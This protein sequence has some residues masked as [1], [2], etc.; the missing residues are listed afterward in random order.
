MKFYEAI[1]I[2]PLTVACRFFWYFFISVLWNCWEAL[3][4]PYAT[5]QRYKNPPQPT[6]GNARYADF[7]TLRKK[8]Y[9]KPVGFL[10]CILRRGYFGK[11]VKVYTRSERS[12][13]IMA[14][15]GAGK[16]QHI[17]A[18]LKD[19]AKRPYPVLP[20]LLVG[21]AGNELF[22]ATGPIFKS[23][24]Y[25]LSK[26]DGVEPDLFT[27]YDILSGLSPKFIDRFK[28]QTR[29][30]GICEAMVA[31]EPNSKHPHFVQFARLLLKCV[32]AVDVLYEGNARPICDLV[33][34]LFDDEAREEMLKRAKAYNDVFISKTLK[35]MQ[36][37]QKNGEGVSMMSTALRKLEPWSDPAI[38]EITTF[39][40]DENGKYYRGWNFTQMYS[41][42]K[43]VVLYIR[44]G[45]EDVGGALARIIYSNAVNE[46]SAIWDETNK[47]L[48]R[49]L[50]IY[51]DEA[52]L[53]GNVSAFIKA[54][55]R[56]R[57]V[58]VRLRLCFVGMDELKKVY[59]DDYKTLLNGCDMTVF[60]GGNDT[61]LFKYASDLAGE[62]TVQSK[63]ESE[64]TNGESRGRSE[65]PRKLVKQDEFRRSERLEVYAYVDNLVVKGETTWR[66]NKKGEI[67]HL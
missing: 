19:V 58:W 41:Q 43:P 7:K 18:D 20:F 10:A 1:T 2:W 62:F 36:D 17:I 64:S 14:P 37:M 59:P 66:K 30:K 61:D 57:K 8:G 11:P 34:I 53:A 29:L 27:K 42:E 22:T 46:V 28:F 6:H 49:E 38:R 31:E 23:V 56:L 24:G 54:F 44:T 26:I 67:E 5:W 16:S 3:R 50:L 12:V 33:D 9:L 39:G 51:V 65:Q 15:P 48:R 63:S 47:P 4:F 13:L 55:S 40:Y 35:T 25:Q 21:D 60:G 45:Y 52:G 32:I